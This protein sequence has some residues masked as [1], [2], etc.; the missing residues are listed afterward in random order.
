MKM[1]DK[2]FYDIFKTNNKF[3]IIVKS[4]NN[5]HHTA[6]P[7]IVNQRLTTFSPTGTLKMFEPVT[8]LVKKLYPN[9]KIICREGDVSKRD[10]AYVDYIQVNTPFDAHYFNNVL[11][12]L[13]YA[14]YELQPMHLT[15]FSYHLDLK[16]DLTISPRQKQALT[17]FIAAN[18]E[19]EIRKF[20]Q[21]PADPLPALKF[22]SLLFPEK[23]YRYYLVQPKNLKQ[24]QMIIP[25]MQ[26]TK[27]LQQLN[28][29][30]FQG[31]GIVNL[32][33]IAFASEQKQTNQN[34]IDLI[35]KLNSSSRLNAPCTIMMRQD[36][37]QITFHLPDDVNYQI[38]SNSAF[39]SNPAY[40]MVTQLFG[41]S[42]D[43]GIFSHV[44]LSDFKKSIAEINQEQAGETQFI[45]EQSVLQQPTI[46][47]TGSQP[48]QQLMKKMLS[49][50]QKALQLM[51][52]AQWKSPQEI[53]QAL[54]Q[55]NGQQA[56]IVEFVCYLI[57][58]QLTDE[59]LQKIS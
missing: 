56:L 46:P 8:Q 40:V 34:F 45:W 43:Q 59:Y 7:D 28:Q 52:D 55:A 3:V 33:T 32:N 35:K 15:E 1:K 57:K 26:V 6:L 51:L 16:Q 29:Q 53:T 36:N 41:G 44:D 14:G 47:V 27:F 2:F 11:L 49:K 25:D 19:K 9:T 18:S 38:D 37:D 10:S 50:P 24:E 39:P 12:A 54:T 5:I 21:L 58:N 42:L 31:Q 30:L 20:L 13:K 22:Q 48:E 17:H 4:Y 23:Q